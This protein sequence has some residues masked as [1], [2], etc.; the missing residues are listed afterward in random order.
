MKSQTLSLKTIMKELDFLK[1]TVN[2]QWN[3]RKKKSTITFAITLTVKMHDPCNAKKQ[4][5][6]F[7]KRKNKK[8]VKQSKVFTQ[9]PI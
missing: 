7:I 2:S 3:I 4:Y 8:S 1:E 6:S 9:Q 5:Q